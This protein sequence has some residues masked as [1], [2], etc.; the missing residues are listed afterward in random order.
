MFQGSGLTH[1]GGSRASRCRASG[2]RLKGFGFRPGVRFR[3]L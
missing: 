3:V 1:V 2:F